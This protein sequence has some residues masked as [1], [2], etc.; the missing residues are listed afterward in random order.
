M[1]WNTKCL[2]IVQRISS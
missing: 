2:V 1:T